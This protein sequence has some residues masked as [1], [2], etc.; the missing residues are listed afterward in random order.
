MAGQMRAIGTESGSR[1]G[2]HAPTQAAAAPEAPPGARLRNL[3]RVCVVFFVLGLVAYFGYVLWQV[4]QPEWAGKT[5]PND[6]SVLWAAARIALEG[7]P[8][9]AF[10]VGRLNAARNLPPDLPEAAYRMAWSYPPQ[11]HALVLPLGQM[12]FVLAWIVW[13]LAGI[14]AF[15]VV[16]RRL[17]PDGNIVAVVSASPAVLMCAIQGQTSLVVGALLAGLLVSLRAD[18]PA[19]A[20]A[21]LGALTIKPQFGPLLPLALAAAGSWRALG[22]AVAATAA[23]VGLTLLWVGPGYWL[24]FAEA[25]GQAAERMAAGWLPRE[26]MISWYAFAVAAG[27]G[28][29]AAMAVQLAVM[30]L[31]AGAVGWAWAGGRAPFALRAAL[32]SVAVPLFSPYVYFYDLVLPLIGVGLVLAGGHVR[33]SASGIAMGAV[34]ALVWAAP[35]LGHFG[36]EA[37][38][39]SAFALVTPPILTAFLALM[40]LEI[41]R[42]RADVPR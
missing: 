20:G 10:D 30:A 19:T 39:G 38:I 13:G 24:A 27:A 28:Q 34:L 11:F 42:G 16:M 21:M 3:A 22:W 4:S 1:V 40:L 18:R 36:L 15:W 33:R 26:L 41:A 2:E 17:V 35:T 6:M 14:T 7:D 32:L 23:I 31:L 25:L 12:P 9:A 8:A 29:Q 37:G 5:S